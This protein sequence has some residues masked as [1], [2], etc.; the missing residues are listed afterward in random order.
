MGTR[1]GTARRVRLSSDENSSLQPVRN[2][3]TFVVRLIV[4]YRSPRRPDVTELRR[5]S[6]LAPPDAREGTSRRATL[7]S[8]RRAAASS[9]ERLAADEPRGFLRPAVPAA[10]RPTF[11][12]AACRAR[13]RAT[14]RGVGATSDP[15]ASRAAVRRPLPVPPSTLR[16]VAPMLFEAGRVRLPPPA[17]C[18]ISTSVCRSSSRGT[19]FMRAGRVVFWPGPCRFAMTAPFSS[20]WCRGEVGRGSAAHSRRGARAPARPDGPHL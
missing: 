10:C 12:S 14:A 5:L 18:L 20:R 9:C 4:S 17:S 8:A 11:R 2:R 13:S 16:L 7:R 15:W 3:R 6:A 19:L 1:I